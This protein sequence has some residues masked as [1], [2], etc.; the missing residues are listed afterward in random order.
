[1]KSQH[2]RIPSLILVP[3]FSSLLLMACGGVADE[4]APAPAVSQTVLKISGSGSASGVLKAIQPAFERDTPGYRL[5][6]LPGSGSGGG[7]KGVVEGV[8]DVAAMARPPKEKEAA[9][10]IK[11]VEF[12]KAAQALIT[13][14]NVGD[15]DLTKAQV[16]SIFTGKHTRWDEVG[17]PDLQILVYARDEGDSST[18]ALRKAILGDAVIPDNVAEVMTSQSTMLAAV[19]GTPGAVG[20]AT[21]PTALAKGAN[22]LAATVDGVAPGDPSYEMINPLGI[23]FL[24]NRQSEVQPLIDWLLSPSGKAAL[25]EYDMIT[26][27]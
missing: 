23:G 16:E 3:L 10:N 18:K 20:I 7:V 12:G 6:V 21:W 14:P 13:H 24:A 9:Q 19:E 26:A 22:V 8:L 17:G 11:F 25:Q 27:N 5:Q 15:L 2:F 1:M 4:P